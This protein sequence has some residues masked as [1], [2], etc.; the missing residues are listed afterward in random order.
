MELRAQ[1]ERE[2]AEAKAASAALTD[3]A[4]ADALAAAGDLVRTRAEAILTANRA[5]VETAAGLDEGLLDRLRLDEQRV[6][7]LA[8]QL[9]A[10]AAL[11][12]LARDVET[13]ML[14]NGL[15]VTERRIP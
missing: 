9:D 10:L 2:A 5:D 3:E 13:W 7:A 14:P 11:E 1:V 12:P 4:V 15:R 6:E 8:A